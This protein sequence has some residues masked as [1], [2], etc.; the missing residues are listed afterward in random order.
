[1]IKGIFTQASACSMCNNLHTTQQPIFKNL[2]A[3]V[4][5]NVEQKN[6]KAH[7]RAE[8]F[9]FSSNPDKL[10]FSF[11]PRLRREKFSLFFL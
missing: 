7:L 3:N 6:L 8:I 4:F 11:Y 2:F 10:R 5:E 9:Y 1:M